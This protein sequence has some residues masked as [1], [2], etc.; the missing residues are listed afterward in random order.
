MGLEWRPAHIGLWTYVPEHIR[1]TE[2]KF[3]QLHPPRMLL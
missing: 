2:A 1:E 3:T